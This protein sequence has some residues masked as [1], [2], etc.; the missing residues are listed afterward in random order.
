MLDEPLDLH[1]FTITGKL[2]N[3]KSKELFCRRLFPYLCFMDRYQC[4]IMSVTSHV[5]RGCFVRPKKNRITDELKQ[6]ENVSI[7]PLTDTEVQNSNSRLSRFPSSV[8]PAAGWA[9]DAGRMDPC[10]HGY[11]DLETDHTQKRFSFLCFSFSETVKTVASVSCS[12]WQW[13]HP[14]WSSASGLACR[15]FRDALLITLDVTSSEFSYCCRPVSE[16]CH[17]PLT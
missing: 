10:F 17:S 2:N 13:W 15:P 4:C 3:Q 1:Y 14:V 9:A 16:F 5:C 6:C 11:S 12:Y 7:H 8:T